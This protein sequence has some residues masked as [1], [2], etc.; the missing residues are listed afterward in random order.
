[1]KQ[2]S[3]GLK[4]KT[5]TVVNSCSDTH[6]WVPYSKGLGI[7]FCCLT[8]RHQFK[9]VVFLSGI[10]HLLKVVFFPSSGLSSAEYQP[11]GKAS[12][13]S[14]NWTLGDTQLEGVN[15]AT[16]RRR[17]SGTMSRLCKHA[18]FTR[19][20]RLHRKVRTDQEREVNLERDGLSQRQ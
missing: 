18:L 8:L 6:K 15:T 11:T 3:S 7:Y 14:V 9:H 4:G 12:C 1:M 5:Q 13:V 19:W 20:N 10:N 16:G 17:D 2:Q